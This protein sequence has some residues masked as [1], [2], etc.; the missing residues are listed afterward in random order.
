MLD[1]AAILIRADA[2]IGSAS[3]PARAAIALLCVAVAHLVK[4]G[5]APATATV[6]LG[7]LRQ[8]HEGRYPEPLHPPGDA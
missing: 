4:V 7:Q 8:V 1:P 3:D 5:G 6:L 2:L